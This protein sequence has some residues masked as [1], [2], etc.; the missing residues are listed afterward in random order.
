MEHHLMIRIHGLL[1]SITPTMI[2]TCSLQVIFQDGLFVPKTQLLAGTPITIEL[3]SDHQEVLAQ[4]M[5]DGTEEH[6]IT[7][8][9]HGFPLVITMMKSFME[10]IVI[11]VTFKFQAKEVEQESISEIQLQ[12]QTL[13]A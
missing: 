1:S 12:T 10:Q 5:E 8:K 7:Q 2:S 6:Q 4:P 11:L 13:N 3:F 9:I